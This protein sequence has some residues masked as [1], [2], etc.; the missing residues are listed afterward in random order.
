MI[1]AAPP[2]EAAAEAA[3]DKFNMLLPSIKDEQLQNILSNKYLNSSVR[4]RDG[5]GENTQLTHSLHQL[6]GGG[7][8]GSALM[9]TNKQDK[10]DGPA[11]EEHKPHPGTPNPGMLHL[12][13]SLSSHS[14][15]LPTHFA[16]ARF[17]FWPVPHLA[18]RSLWWINA[19]FFAKAWK[20]ETCWWK[21]WRQSCRLREGSQ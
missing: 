18:S 13:T 14:S 2:R 6:A 1:S 20:K 4:G 21:K 15:H 5:G 12:S 17:N 16:F 3:G 10:R 7:V 19:H 8:R 9:L 11:T